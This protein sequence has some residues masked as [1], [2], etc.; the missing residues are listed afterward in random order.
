MWTKTTK[1]DD[2]KIRD[3]INIDKVRKNK[4]RKKNKTQNKREEKDLDIPH[5]N[6]TTRLWKKEKITFVNMV[7]KGRIMTKMTHSKTTT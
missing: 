1:I 3:K 7:V 6:P 2:K 4:R 5:L